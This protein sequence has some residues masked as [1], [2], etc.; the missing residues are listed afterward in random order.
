MILK[1]NKVILRPVRKD[2]YNLIF[3]WF[4]DNEII[5][6]LIGF[7]LQF[8]ID[9]ALN[10]CEMASKT[11]RKDIKWIIETS[12]EKPEAIGFVGLYNIDL[13][14]RNAES[15]IVI[16]E[17]SYWGKGMGSESLKLICDFAFNYLGLKLVYAY[18]LSD[19]EASLNLYKKVGF[20][21]EGVLRKRIF[22]KG[23]WHDV[24]LLSIQA[25]DWGN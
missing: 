10:W 22:R 15:A 21:E 16:G 24:I 25:E 19:N 18:I 8:S 12:D 9:D 11:D 2:D 3:K 6:K 5:D 1:G 17:K 14:N 4:N 13:L 20:K 7:R 23:F